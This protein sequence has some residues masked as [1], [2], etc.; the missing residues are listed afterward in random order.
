MYA[1]GSGRGRVAVVVGHSL[2]QGDI[3]SHTYE[4][5]TH[6]ESEWYSLIHAL[7]I[8]KHNKYRTNHATIYMDSQLV[9][10]QFN[11]TWKCRQ[12]HLKK[13]AKMAWE[14]AELLALRGVE[15]DVKWL[16]REKNV[17]GWY[18]DQRK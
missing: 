5:D 14:M 13:I 6:N 12:Y 18:L 2:R 11:E 15:I 17:A 10:N 4:T 8:L 1:D 9:V 3:Y 16:K 7:K